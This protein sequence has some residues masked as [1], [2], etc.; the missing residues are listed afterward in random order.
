MVQ[1]VA[2]A[3]CGGA[4]CGYWCGFVDGVGCMAWR[5]RQGLQMLG[6]V[7]AHVALVCG[8]AAP[9]QVVNGL[10]QSSIWSLLPSPWTRAAWVTHSSV[11]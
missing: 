5:P 7:G 6:V 11:N 4:W 8:E 3:R 1:G 10:P 2:H 9:P